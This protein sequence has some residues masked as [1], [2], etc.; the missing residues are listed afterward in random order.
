V[1]FPAT[2]LTYL[3]PR[4]REAL[5]PVAAYLAKAGIT[6]NQVTLTSLAGSVLAGTLLCV[7]ATHPAL[8]GLLPVWLWMRM[9]CATLDGTLAIEFGQKSRIG[10]ILNEVGDVV[11]DVAL[12]LPFAFVPP[13]PAHRLPCL[14]FLPVSPSWPAWQGRS[15]GAAGGSTVH[16][17]NPTARLRSRCLR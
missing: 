13:F 15:W 6:A 10:G 16:L 11:S 3:K 9:A 1:F 7:H 5:R 14:S 2:S 8:F 4:F 12:L 17:G